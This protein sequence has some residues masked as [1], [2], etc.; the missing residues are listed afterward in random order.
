MKQDGFRIVAL[1][2]GERVQVWTRR[3]ADFTDRFPAIADAVR[4]P[5]AERR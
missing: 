4:G 3:G 1:K 2:Q 5:P